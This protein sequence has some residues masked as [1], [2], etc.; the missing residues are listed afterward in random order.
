MRLWSLRMAWTQ[1]VGIWAKVPGLVESPKRPTLMPLKVQDRVCEH[2]IE[3]SMCME[4]Y[5][6]A[7]APHQVYGN[8]G[9]AM[10]DM[11]TPALVTGPETAEGDRLFALF[12]VAVCP[13]LMDG[14]AWFFL[15]F[16]YLPCPLPYSLLFHPISIFFPFRFSCIFLNFCFYSCLGTLWKGALS[17]ALDLAYLRLLALL[18]ISDE[19]KLPQTQF[20]GRWEVLWGLAHR[21][22]Q[23]HVSSLSCFPFELQTGLCL[24]WYFQNLDVIMENN[25][26]LSPM[27]LSRRGELSNACCLRAQ[28]LVWFE[29]T[30]VP[31]LEEVAQLS[32]NTGL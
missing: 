18:Q 29:H 7:V 10:S 19:W 31:N 26:H 20:W 3:M 5:R 6:D 11:K 24:I 4:L 2:S 30:Q 9:R 17:P 23:A 27:L 13:D 25:P 1:P 14:D 32:D 15:L 21:V 16:P 8:M 28:Q 22:R 12:V